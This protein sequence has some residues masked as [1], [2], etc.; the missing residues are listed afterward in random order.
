MFINLEIERMRRHMS[1]A[2]MACQLSVP[3]ETLNGWISGRLAIPAEK[4]RALSRLFYGC[5]IDYLLS[6]RR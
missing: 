4:L 1:R 6:E 5:S 2:K 3:I